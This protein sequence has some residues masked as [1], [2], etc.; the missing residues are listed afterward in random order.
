M[1]GFRLWLGALFAL[2]LAACGQGSVKSPDFSSE[3]VSISI[4]PP[5]PLTVGQGET[6]QFSASGVHSSQPGQPPVIAPV[7]GVE[8]SSSNPAIVSINSTTGLATGGA[9]LGTATI[10]AT[11]GKV[12]G[13]VQVTSEGLVLR[14]LVITPAT[15]VVAPGGNATYILQGRFSDS[16]TPRDLGPDE[17]INWSIAP[18][19]GFPGVAATLSNSSGKTVT[20][21]A[22]TVEGVATLTALVPGRAAPLNTAT[23]KFIIGQVKSLAIVPA[24]ASQPVGL[25]QEFKAIASFNSITGGAVIPD[26][27]VPATWT[28]TT[29][30][31]QQ[32]TL[33][34]ACD[35][36]SD[37]S[38][39]CIITGRAVGTVN[40]TAVYLLGSTP[41]N[42]TATLT[43]T[44]AVLTSV[45]IEAV[46][47]GSLAILP[48]TTI[49]PTRRVNVGI[50]SASNFQARYHYSDGLNDL[51]PRD[52]SQLATWS[53][54]DTTGNIATVSVNP[55]TNVATVTAKAKTPANAPVTLT[56]TVNSTIKDEIWVN[57]GDATLQSLIGIRPTKAYIALGRSQEF[58]AVG[59]FSDGSDADI[60]DSLIDWTSLDT[61]IATINDANGVATASS[62]IAK[63]GQSTKI[64]A[65][66]TSNP[67]SVVEADFTVTS[68]RCTVP[69]YATD[70][71]QAFETAPQ[72][73]CLLCGT[74]NLPRVIDFSELTFGQINVGVAALNGYRGVDVKIDPSA[75][76]MPLEVGSKPAFI[77]SLPKGPLVL[78]QV[79][80]QL[81]ISTLWYTG[82]VPATVESSG[83][84][85]PLRVDLLGAQ[86]I[87]LDGGLTESQN[88][89]LVA[90]DSS[91]PFNGVRL[92]VKG[93]TAN[94]LSTVNVFQACANS[95]PA[96][97]TLN[98]IGEIVTIPTLVGNTTIVGQGVTFRAKT[99]VGADIPPPDVTWTSSNHAVAPDPSALGN[100]T[101]VGVGTTTITATLVD[102]SQC[103]GA[104][105]AT[106]TLHVIQSYCEAPFA[107]PTASVQRFIQGL[108]VLCST[109]DLG[110]VIDPFLSTAAT[111]N[112][113]VGLLNGGVAIRVNANTPAPFPAGQ[114]VGF[115]VR[116]STG[117]VLT[118]E[119]LSQLE[120]RTLL[121]GA[122]AETFSQ[123]DLNVDLL[124]I[125]LLDIGNPQ[126]LIGQVVGLGEGVLTTQPFNSVELVF[127][128]GVASA[129]S[130]LEIYSACPNITVPDAP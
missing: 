96:T 95:D 6:I 71:A 15:A 117:A 75:P 115:L 107:A 44:P 62:D 20:V 60:A 66:L 110:N 52:L 61:S 23:A 113:P 12:K 39:T 111:V 17:V 87:A 59:H 123:T 78:A 125:P 7:E 28:A 38:S 94:A 124:S 79:L 2:V 112:V 92:K 130:Q 48:G 25:P 98:G 85:V 46:D 63:V 13:T 101:P 82:V 43:V 104:C 11:K 102:Q 83:D 73:V 37:T 99:L 76:Y 33:D 120:F 1:K 47:P 116:R 35:S 90:I 57:I 29:A 9:T 119:V 84:L 16:P 81:E 5:G 54:S 109:S 103:T 36:A 86:V 97:P 49:N 89:Y 121:D 45:A 19:A 108:C 100:I 27:E 34:S 10:T 72:G 18:D 21:T 14:A 114:R 31:A 53:I 80:N 58:V 56:A 77:I 91:L 55:D 22:G 65:R 88:Q 40:I 24:T 68:T 51:T 42:A 64:R 128:S 126:Q 74:N 105:T 4:A 50:G 69:L 127:K 8:W 32:P 106:Y 118:A 3:L 122:V 30:A 67:S 26:A 70:G 129:L 93:G 41:F